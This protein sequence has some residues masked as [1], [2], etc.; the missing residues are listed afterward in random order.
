MLEQFLLSLT[1]LA[2]SLLP[3]PQQGPLKPCKVAGVDEQLLCGKLSVFENRQTR[4]G[5]KINLNVVVLP[6]LDQQHKEAP[7]FDLAGGPGIASTSAAFDY[8]TALRNYRR[9]RDVV[10]VDQRGTG[11]SNPLHCKNNDPH[12]LREMYSTRYVDDCRRTLERVA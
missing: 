4:T 10:L 3:G 6:A 1:V 9:H 12:Y 11:E 7:L 5:R 2:T 8:A